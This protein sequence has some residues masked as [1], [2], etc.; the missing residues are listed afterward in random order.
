MHLT[1]PAPLCFHEVW[2]FKVFLYTVFPPVQQR[3]FSWGPLIGASLQEVRYLEDPVSSTIVL[4]EHSL[5]S[6]SR[7][8]YGAR[9]TSAAPF[10][11]CEPWGSEFTCLC[12]VP[13][14]QW[15]GQNLRPGF[16]FEVAGLLLQTIVHWT[17]L[18]CVHRLC[19]DTLHFEHRMD[20]VCS[21]SSVSIFRVSFTFHIQQTF[22][23]PSPGSVYHGSLVQVHM[24]TCVS[25]L[26]NYI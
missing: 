19:T 23:C 1:L 21:D 9:W 14:D 4:S 22:H 2:L 10:C 18:S 24:Y 26:T 13:W 6:S 25:A 8:S 11:R 17:Y 12:K 16:L 20:S 7:H 3:R 5:I 15:Q